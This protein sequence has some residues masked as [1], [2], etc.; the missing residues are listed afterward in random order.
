MISY[1]FKS[2]AKNILVAILSAVFICL[3]CNE[4]RKYVLVASWRGFA[5]KT[6]DLI[7][8]LLIFLYMV[9][10]KY[11]YKIKQWLF[12]IAFAVLALTTVFSIRDIF[13]SDTFNLTNHFIAGLI[14]YSRKLVIIVGYILAFLGSLSNFKRI[15][16]LRLGLCLQILAAII[17]AVS[18]YNHLYLS[19][20]ILFYN[21][22]AKIEVIMP[23]FIHISILILTFTKKSKNIDITSFVEKRKM[24]REDKKAEK[25]TRQNQEETSPTVVPD[26]SWRCMGCG[27]ILSDET[28]VCNCG[29]KR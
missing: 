1:I 10:M 25:L 27:E 3:E 12:P 28:S 17:L 15:N 6:V 20:N 22:N 14:G 29:Y 11:E 16:F 9:T 7:P 5:L 2:K 19:G 8:Y 18:Y 26:G 4:L 24:K 13:N 23:T 21:L